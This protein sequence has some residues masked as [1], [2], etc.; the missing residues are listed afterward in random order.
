MKQTT[1]TYG[2]GAGIF[3]LVALVG[4]VLWFFSFSNAKNQALFAAA[5]VV[6]IE[7]EDSAIANAEETLAE[8][9]SDEVMLGAY[10]VSREDIVSFLEE[11]ERSGDML[12][13]VVEVASVTNTPGADGRLTLSMRITGSFES[14]M[15][16]LGSIEYGARDM[17]V[18]SLTL[19]TLRSEEG[20]DPWVGAVVFSVAT[21][22]EKP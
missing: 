15:K 22:E 20:G 10:F 17:R 5:E 7:Q 2:I 19:D 13:S 21:I 12:G 16:T 6:R 14:V 4:Y 1:L 18:E 3:A 9:A 8:L 11:L